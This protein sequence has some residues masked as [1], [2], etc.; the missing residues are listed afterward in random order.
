MNS[1][2]NKIDLENLFLKIIKIAIVKID[3]SQVKMCS[4]KD[5]SP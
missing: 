4:A 3:I 5:N 2:I 1:E